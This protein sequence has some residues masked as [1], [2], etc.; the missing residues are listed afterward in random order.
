MIRHIVMWKLKEENKK[1]NKQIIKEKLEGLVGKIL[2]LE[3]ANV[4]F[5]CVVNETNY[6]AVLVAD[7]IDR[8]SIANYQVN[9]LHVKISE[10]VKEVRLDRASIDFEI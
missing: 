7:F 4:Y 9:P 3:S 2:G 5:N 1:E 8:Q 6:D 10:F